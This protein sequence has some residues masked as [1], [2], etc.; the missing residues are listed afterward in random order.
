MN[1]RSVPA[2]PKSFPNAHEEVFLELLL[3]DDARFAELFHVWKQRTVLATMDHA[4]ARLLPLLYKR[5]QIHAPTD[6]ML[7]TLRGVYKATWARNQRLL[8]GAERALDLLRQQH[9]DTLVLKGIPLLLDVYKDMGARFLS[10]V[11]VLIHPRH[12]RFVMRLLREH[13]WRLHSPYF[14][15]ED[16]LSEEQIRRAV[17]EVTFSNDQGIELDVHWDLFEFSERDQELYAFDRLWERSCVVQNGAQAYRA[18]SPEDALVHSVVHGAEGNPHRTLR[19]VTDAVALIR[20]HDIR[21]SDVFERI[22]HTDHRIDVYTAFRFLEER[23]CVVFPK[24]FAERIHQ[25]TFSKKER[26][27]Y[28]QRANVSIAAWGRLP[29]LWKMYWTY[30]CRG[31]HVFN[32]WA[33]LCM[34]LA[35]AWG[36]RRVRDLVPFVITKIY[37]R[38]RRWL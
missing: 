16:M 25:A 22:E 38:A 7:P 26:R 8:H 37:Q 11:D 21:W 31:G 33:G 24:S 20:A 14:P 35:H 13:G 27:T 32:R 1:N 18:L 19:W 28:A 17:K 34:Y 4:S 12:I 9:I 5:I 10:D 23:G 6:D 3:C 2:F 29:H 30:E 15:C 36:F